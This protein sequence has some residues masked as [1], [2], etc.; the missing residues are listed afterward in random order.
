[1]FLITQA[2]ENNCPIEHAQQSVGHAQLKTTQMHD[3]RVIKKRN[4]A[5]FAVRY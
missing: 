5:S 2:L 4:S 1:M 3:K